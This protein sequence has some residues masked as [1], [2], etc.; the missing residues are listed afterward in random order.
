MDDP[1]PTLRA[2]VGYY[3]EPFGLVSFPDLWSLEDAAALHSLSS[4]FA[5]FVDPETEIEL[6]AWER[7]HRPVY[8]RWYDAL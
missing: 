5:V 3:L 4:N 1:R 6:A 8:K 7:R 2:L